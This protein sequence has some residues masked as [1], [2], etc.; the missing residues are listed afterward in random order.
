ME[1]YS[2]K[3]NI[4]YMGEVFYNPKLLINNLLNEEKLNYFSLI[5]LFIFTIG[6]ECLYVIDYFTQRPLILPI[7]N[8]LRLLTTSDN[9]YYFSQIILFP[10][11]HIVDFILF[12]ICGNMM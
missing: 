5:P 6:Y 8:L 10:I 7:T 12:W 4:K 3:R 9:Q 2:L 1:N 11:V